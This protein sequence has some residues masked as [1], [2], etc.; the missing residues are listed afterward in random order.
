MTASITKSAFGNVDGKEVNLYVLTNAK[1]WVMKVTNY[2]A[3][4]TEFHVP[5]R[6]G[7]FAD[8]GK[9]K[10]PILRGLSGRAPYF[11]NGSAMTLLDVVNFHDARFKIG[12]TAQVQLEQGLSELVDWW[13]AQK[14]E[15]TA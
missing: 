9:V 12:F 13:R 6:T 14:N 5:D 7:K 2:G 8:I 11:H 1:G 3:I 4:V 15:V 10:V